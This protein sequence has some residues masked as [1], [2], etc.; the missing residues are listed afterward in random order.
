MRPYLSSIR[1]YVRLFVFF[2]KQH[3][4]DLRWGHRRQTQTRTAA[5]QR[6]C[7]NH[8][9][10]V[11]HDVLYCSKLAAFIGP[12]GP[13]SRIELRFVSYCCLQCV[14]HDTG[15]LLCCCCC[16]AML[17]CCNTVSSTGPLSRKPFSIAVSTSSVSDMHFLI[18]LAPGIQIKFIY[19]LVLWEVE[20]D[21][22]NWEWE[23]RC[24]HEAETTSYGELMQRRCRNEVVGW[25][26]GMVGIYHALVT[27][28]VSGDKMQDQGSELLRDLNLGIEDI[29]ILSIKVVGDWWTQGSQKVI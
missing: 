14:V 21:F 20:V 6:S 27:C 1:T 9:F 11:V 22:V 29:W 3:S 4:H 15:T 2:A 16:W 13:A 28:K 5:A 25:S 24:W 12:W 18:D 7:D 10:T 8:L 23:V 26:K 19:G 17:C